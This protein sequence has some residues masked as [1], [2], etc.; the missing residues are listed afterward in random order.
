M[1]IVANTAYGLYRV[2]SNGRVLI[3][4]FSVDG[5]KPCVPNNVFSDFMSFCIRR[6][7]NWQKDITELQNESCV[8]Q[9]PMQED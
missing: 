6:G 7:N 9:I 1:H 2:I 5:K 4:T 3:S 8:F